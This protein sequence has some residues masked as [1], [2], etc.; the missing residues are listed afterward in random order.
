MNPE[1]Q[2]ILDV[3]LKKDPST[4]TAD[5]IGFLRARRDYLKKS[6]LDEYD[7]V[8]NP[9]AKKEEAPKVAAKEENQT[10]AKTGTVNN[11]AKQ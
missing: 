1:A 3:I 10:P 8:L 2:A 11:N 5:D 7:E 9:K 4:L 6:Q